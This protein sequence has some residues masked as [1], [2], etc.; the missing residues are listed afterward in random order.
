M[1]A[2][3]ASFRDPAGFMYKDE[4]GILLRQVNE[5]GAADYDLFVSSGLYDTLA[6][7]RMLVRHKV[8]PGVQAKGVHTTLRPDVV[9]FI[10]YPFEWSF[11]Q[12]KD[13]ALLTLNIQKQALKHGMS[14]KDASA[15]NVQFVDGRP[16]FIDTLSFETYK[17]GTAWAAY[18]QFCQHFLA[19]LALMAYTDI[20]LS[21]LL[22]VHLDGIPLE[23]TA[24]LL[25]RRARLKLS[26]VIHLVLHARAQRTKAADHK[27]PTAVV[28]RSSLDA[29]IDSLERTIR[30]LQPRSDSSEWGDYYKN[31]TNYSAKAADA[32][33][34]VIVDMVKPLKAKSVLDLG[35]N[36]GEYSRPLNKLGLTAVC[37][38]ID[39]NAV[40]ANYRHVRLHKETQ[41]LPLLVDLTNP[42]GNLGWQNNERQPI[43]ER[44]Q[45]TVV[46]A[47]AIVHHLAISNNL[48]LGNI[49]E[50]FAKFGPYL[51]IEFV[52]KADSQVQKLLSTRPDIFPDY[53]EEGLKQAFS[54]YYKLQKEVKIKGTKRT[55]Y[56]FKTK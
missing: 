32:K 43:H 38:D 34:K 56:L 40:E 22:R 13:A 12:L 4:R 27:R 33:A 25:P 18:R 52:P 16:L 17:P 35:G 55:L 50:Y 44:L 5:V 37:T 23:L 29:I 8:M 1:K 46:M 19:P 31:N 3:Q 2:S 26:L 48:P 49:A 51:I 7:K 6:A 11:S 41:M 36:N 45:T 47:L 21:Q 10:S 54:H 39:P 9:P 15:Y 14:L 20:N 30:K 53:N 24:K 28:S 42:G